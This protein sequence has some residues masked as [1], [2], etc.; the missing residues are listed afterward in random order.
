MAKYRHD[1][2]HRHGGT[3]LTD[4]GQITELI[5]REGVDLPHLAAFTLLDSEAGRERLKRYYESY[6]DDR[7]AS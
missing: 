4:G 6:L 7:A 3:F 2:P 1:L 5:F